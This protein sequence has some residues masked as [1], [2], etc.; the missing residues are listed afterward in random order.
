M[1]HRDRS[2]F[3]G[4]YEADVCRL[5]GAVAHR[6]AGGLCGPACVVRNQAWNA[7]VRIPQ[8]ENKTCRG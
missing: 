2:P 4:Q 8:S 7:A 3:Q 5:G 6:E 1:E